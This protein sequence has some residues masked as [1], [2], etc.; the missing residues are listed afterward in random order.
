LGNDAENGLK[1]YIEKPL[2]AQIGDECKPFTPAQISFVFGHSHKPF[3]RYNKDT[4]FAGY[5]VRLKVYNS[6]GWV[7]DGDKLQKLHGGAVILIDENYDAVSLRLYNETDDPNG[8]EVKVQEAMDPEDRNYTPSAF[9]TR[10]K[11]LLP[12]ST[13]FAGIVTKAIGVRRKNLIAREDSPVLIS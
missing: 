10:I 11:G 2:L 9:L 3:E 8:Y 4:D 12:P 5:P 7:V 1:Q 6:G 13:D